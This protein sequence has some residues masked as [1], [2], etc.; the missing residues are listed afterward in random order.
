M[1]GPQPA[2]SLLLA[3]RE[4]P[5]CI[6]SLCLNDLTRILNRLD[7]GDRTA[8]EELLPLVYHELRQMASRKMAGE[9]QGP[10]P[11]SLEVD[12]RDA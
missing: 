12:I 8:A 11:V 6:A 2:M 5:R 3:V 1:C 4:S 10:C 7:K 9:P